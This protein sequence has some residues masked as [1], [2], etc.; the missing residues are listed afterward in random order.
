G[1]VALALHEL[2]SGSRAGAPGGAPPLLLVHALE[3]STRDWLP[4][5]EAIL[6]A[7]RGPV[8]AIDLAGHGESEWRVGGAYTPELF[9]A[10]VDAVL[11][12]I[13]RSALAGAGVGAYACLL[14][15]AARR[16]L[17]PGAAL[18]P[19]RG[20]AG[21]GAL[22]VGSGRAPVVAPDAR[23]RASAV[24]ATERA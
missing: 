5:G 12:S 16:D 11:A 20:L 6:A 18:L 9:A 7:W 13:G 1:E 8:F 17:V 23:A 24:G 21:G 2:R 10:D 15:A 19:G 22:P 4:H 14:V 3:G